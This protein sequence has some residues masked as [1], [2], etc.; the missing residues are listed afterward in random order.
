MKF[1]FVCRVWVVD[2]ILKLEKYLVAMTLGGR[3]FH[4]SP[5]VAETMWGSFSMVAKERQ[6]KLLNLV[7]CLKRSLFFVKQLYI[8]L[9]RIVN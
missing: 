8:N 9:D 2:L 4:N 5:P 3:L 1:T 7:T 6:R